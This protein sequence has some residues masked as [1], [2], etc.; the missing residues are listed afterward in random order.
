MDMTTIAEDQGLSPAG[1][2][3]CLDVPTLTAHLRQRLAA[4]AVQTD[5]MPHVVVTDVFPSETYELLLQSIPRVECFVSDGSTK[6]NWECTN[7]YSAPDVVKEVWRRMDS[8]WMRQCVLP[9]VIDSFRTNLLHHYE[10]LF[11]PDLA[12][13]AITAQVARRGRVMLRR[14]GYHLKPHRD[15]LTAG[16]TLLLYL[17]RPDDEESYGTQLYRVRND[18]VPDRS[19]TYYPPPEACEE[20]VNVPFRPNSALV[21]L[22]AVGAAHGATIPRTAPLDLERYSYQ[23]YIGVELGRLAEVLNQLTGDARARWAPKL[24]ERR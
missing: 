14:P 5:P 11:G 9:L 4:I 20:V 15:P 17:A 2:Q 7:E 24:F 22:N 6:Q 8:D 16:M 21:F 23:A 1:I 19:K 18:R 13:T 12:E 3:Q 10:Q